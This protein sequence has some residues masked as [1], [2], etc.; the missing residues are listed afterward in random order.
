M[1]RDVGFHLKATE[2][3]EAR[4]PMR[5]LEGDL[6]SVPVQRLCFDRLKIFQILKSLIGANLWALIDLA[7]PESRAVGHSMSF[8]DFLESPR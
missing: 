6:G 2:T 1:L 5:T 3:K 7:A 8:A 4:D